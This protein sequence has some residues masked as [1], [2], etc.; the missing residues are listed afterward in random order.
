MALPDIFHGFI[1]L[2]KCDKITINSGF[3][4]KYV[5]NSNESDCSDYSLAIRMQYAVMFRVEARF[6]PLIRFIHYSYW[7]WH[8]EALVLNVDIFE[9]FFESTSL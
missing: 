5:M 6:G 8:V 2:R 7:M 1:K 3:E 9:T 4:A